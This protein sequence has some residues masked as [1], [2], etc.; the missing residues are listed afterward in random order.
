MRSISSDCVRL[1]TTPNHSIF[2]ILNRF[3][4]LH[5]GWRYNSSVVGRQLA[6]TC[7]H[8]ATSDEWARWP[9]WCRPRSSRGCWRSTGSCRSCWAAR[10]QPTP[11]CVAWRGS[12][13]ARGWSARRTTRTGYSTSRRARSRPV[14]RSS[15]D[16]SL[17]AHTIHICV[18]QSSCYIR[19]ST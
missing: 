3:S 19:Y 8:R 11:W 1:L 9:Y 6:R 13:W 12:G 18:N 5:S 17:S 10:R 2:H 16:I 14:V 4:H 7:R 15:A